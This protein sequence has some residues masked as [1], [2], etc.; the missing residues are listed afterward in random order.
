MLRPVPLG[1]LETEATVV[2]RGRRAMVIDAALRAEVAVVARASSQWIAADLA[3]TPLEGTVPARP[4]V[5]S[6][7]RASGEFEYPLP[8]FNRDVA[9]LRYLL[10]LA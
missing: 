6:D 9:E 2:K 1:V 5:P 7:G 3:A 10:G 8:G 4:D